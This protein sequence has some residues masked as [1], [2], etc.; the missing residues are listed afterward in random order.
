M[1]GTRLGAVY[2]TSSRL[3]F[4]TSSQCGRPIIPLSSTTITK[5]SSGPC[6][7]HMM[8]RLE[9]DQS[10]FQLTPHNFP[11]AS[12]TTWNS[13]TLPKRFFLLSKLIWNPNRT[14]ALPLHPVI[15]VTTIPFAT[16]A[17]TNTLTLRNLADVYSAVTGQG[18]TLPG[19]VSLPPM[20]VD[21]HVIYSDKV[22]RVRG[23]PS[24]AKPIVLLEMELQDVT[25][26]PCASTANIVAHSV[27]RQPTMHQTATSSNFF[28]INIPFIA[29]TWRSMLHNTSLF[30]KFSDVPY[31]IQYGFDMGINNLPSHTFTPLNHKSAL[32]F[33][34]HVL[35][36]I[37][38]KLS[39]QCYSGPFSRSRLESLIGPFCTS[40]LGTVLKSELPDERCIV[41]DLSFPRNDLSRHSVNDHININDFRCDWG[42]FNDVKNIVLDAPIGTEAATLNVDSAFRCCP[43]V[44]SQQPNF[45]IHWNDLFIL[46]TMLHLGR[47]VQEVSSGESQTRWQQYCHYRGSAHWRTE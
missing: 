38:T 46:I 3:I 30:N 7:W 1:S 40:P 6:T 41:Q 17:T 47:Q 32:S 9:R 20:R 5:Q 19:T 18:L 2:L 27:A 4:Q 23:W 14:L 45:I 33:P 12:E 28:V 29:D 42:T 39:W 37:N 11:L 25:T 13:D 43:I 16:S 44:P 21:H 15:L 35:S 22:P 34:D 26:D 31:S 8:L 36:H 10:S 24:L